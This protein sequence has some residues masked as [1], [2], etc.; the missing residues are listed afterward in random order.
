VRIAAFTL[1]ATTLTGVLTGVA[2]ALQ[3][4][5]SDVIRS[6]KSGARDGVVHHSRLRATL[7]LV[8]TALSALLLI[9]AGLF[10][11]SL[12]EVGSLDYGYDPARLLVVDAELPETVTN[13]GR[14]ALYDQMFEHA[15]HL[16][17]VERAALSSMVPF[18]SLMAT[19]LSIPDFDS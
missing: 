17:G 12:R 11:R 19:D 18:W 4:L 15:R 1:A 10:V 6:L 7:L 5:S 14:I 9:G 2:P 13:E 3:L 8:Q 16:P